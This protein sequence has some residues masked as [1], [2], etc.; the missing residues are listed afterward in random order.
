MMV[1]QLKDQLKAQR[2]KYCKQMNPTAMRAMRGLDQLPKPLL[3]LHCGHGFSLLLAL[4]KVVGLL[5]HTAARSHRGPI[6]PTHT[7]LCMSKVLSEVRILCT[8]QVE[9]KN[10]ADTVADMQRR[11]RG[12]QTVKGL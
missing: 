7:V 2:D 11:C 9:F 5:H 12:L 8:C 3:M 4:T 6:P 10:K 1:F